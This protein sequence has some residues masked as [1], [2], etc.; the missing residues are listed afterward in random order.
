M[1]KKKCAHLP[2]VCVPPEGEEYCAQF[3]KDAGSQ[4]TE[5]TQVDRVRKP[6]FLSLSWVTA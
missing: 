3:C 1:A 4:E 2:C 5:I 6:Y